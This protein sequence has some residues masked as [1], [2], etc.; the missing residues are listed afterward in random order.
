MLLASRGPTDIEA[1]GGNDHGEL[2]IG[3]WSPTYPQL[4]YHILDDSM[5]FYRGV[6]W[7]LRDNS[8]ILS[9]RVLRL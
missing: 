7:S 8:V 2:L 6:L 1:R 5:T 3:I 4:F 9:P